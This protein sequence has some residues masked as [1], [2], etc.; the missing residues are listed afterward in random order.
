MVGVVSTKGLQFFLPCNEARSEEKCPRK[1]EEE[2]TGFVNHMNFIE[3]IF[4]CRD[5]EYV[6]ITPKQLEEVRKRGAEKG[7]FRAL[8]Q[9]DENTKN[10]L[11]KKEIL[12]ILVGLPEEEP[13]ERHEVSP[14]Y[15]LVHSRTLPSAC[16]FDLAD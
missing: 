9:L 14:I 7:W 6:D 13:K 10:E 12:M 16:C 8:N 5:D 3:T 1:K 11:S 2:G 4:S 15:C